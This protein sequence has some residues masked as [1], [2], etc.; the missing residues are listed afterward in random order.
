MKH[1]F[2]LLVFA[3]LV[4]AVQAAPVTAQTGASRRQIMLQRYATKAAVTKALTAEGFLEAATKGDTETIFSV[5]DITLFDQ[6]DKFSNNCFHLAKDEATLQALAAVIRRLDENNSRRIIRQL[7]NQRNNMGE[8]PLMRQINLGKAQMFEPLYRGSELAES[9]R[10][11]RSVSKGGALNIPAKIKEGITKSLS[12]DNSGRTVAQAALA[13]INE[14]GMDK[15]VAYF[16]EHAP[17]LLN[18]F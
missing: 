6:T 12:K 7:R 1:I 5:K 9:I 2:F 18:N 4:P 13:N 3:L 8:T 17:Y 15:V 16:E 11:T 10:E 14:P